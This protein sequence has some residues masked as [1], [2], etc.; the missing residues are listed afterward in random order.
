LPSRL[1]PKETLRGEGG[2]YPHQQSRQERFPSLVWKEKGTVPV[3]EY[4]IKRSSYTS[5]QRRRPH[6]RGR[7]IIQPGK[8][9]QCRLRCLR[10]HL[11]IIITP[12]HRLPLFGIFIFLNP[13]YGNCNLSRSEHL[14]VSSKK[15]IYG[16]RDKLF[17][18]NRT[19][20]RMNY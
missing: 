14:P 18:V 9:R 13:L 11:S 7:I 2:T 8:R 1:T 17:E 20:W 12:M 5:Y 4:R 16:N 3:S 19:I 6:R 10:G 15:G